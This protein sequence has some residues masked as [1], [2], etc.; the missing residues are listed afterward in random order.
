MQFFLIMDY[1]FCDEAEEK[2]EIEETHDVLL[3]L[4][5]LGPLIGFYSGDVEVR[6]NLNSSLKIGLFYINPILN[7]LND[8]VSIEL[9][10][11]SPDGKLRTYTEDFYL[12]GTSLQYNVL[13]N[14]CFPNSIYLGFGTSF[15]LISLD[16]D[17]HPEL[18]GFY[19]NI[20]PLILIGLQAINNSILYRIEL[21]LQYSFP[22][23]EIEKLFTDTMFDISKAK[24]F[25]VYFNISIGIGL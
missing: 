1:C 16:D 7:L 9:E 5:I 19:N 22:T 11:T 17:T 10:V 6:L 4:N 21:G 18:S 12:I 14:S 23:V 24:G 20:T 8:I 25:G 15:V 2:V 13:L 3:S